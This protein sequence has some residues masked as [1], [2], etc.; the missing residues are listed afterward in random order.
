MTATKHTDPTPAPLP[1]KVQQLPTSIDILSPSGLIATVYDDEH[2]FN[3][4]QTAEFLVKSANAHP[5]FVALLKEALS[6]LSHNVSEEPRLECAFRIAAAL[7]KSGDW[8][9]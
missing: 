6:L 7:R 1:Y 4:R 5:D 8:V 9:K 2:Q 3:H